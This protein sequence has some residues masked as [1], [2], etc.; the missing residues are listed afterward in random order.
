MPIREQKA[1]HST[2]TKLVKL[3]NDTENDMKS[4]EV[5]LAMFSYYSKAFWHY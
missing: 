2:L 5:T 3:Q 1:H 4:W